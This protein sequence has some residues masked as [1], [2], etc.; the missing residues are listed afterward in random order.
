MLEVKIRKAKISDAR[1]IYILGK[2]I[3]ELGFSSKYPFHELSEIKE[4]I[5][6]PKENIMLIAQHKGENIGFIFAKIL[7]H[8]AGG[9][10]MLDNLGVDFE[11]RRNG[12]G[13]KL[14]NALYGEIKHRN[15]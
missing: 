14:L 9:W 3:H 4:F 10:C 12:V 6:A 8:S 15:I 1:A 5:S 2:R 7:A 11:H 13:E